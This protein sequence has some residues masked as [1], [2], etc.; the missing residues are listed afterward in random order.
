[1]PSSKYASAYKKP[2]GSVEDEGIRNL[3][4]LPPHRH[5]TDRPDTEQDRPAPR[6]LRPI[7]MI[8]AFKLP[9]SPS[10]PT[11][12][13]QLCPSSKPKVSQSSFPINL[14]R[15]TELAGAKA[16]PRKTE[17]SIPSSQK[18]DCWIPGTSLD[19]LRM[20]D[21][22]VLLHLCLPCHVGVQCG[23]FYFKLERRVSNQHPVQKEKKRGKYSTRRVPYYHW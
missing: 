12:H 16:I 13:F 14:N 11:P 8:P 5:P 1:M 3:P 23:A 6:F 21:R 9:Q 4:P 22:W 19:W 2:T 7:I 10:S 17:P 15:R 20:L 18:T